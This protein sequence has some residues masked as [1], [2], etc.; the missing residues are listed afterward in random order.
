SDI[1]DKAARLSFSA[2]KKLSVQMKLN[3][4]KLGT[5]DY[6]HTVL[7]GGNTSLKI[8]VLN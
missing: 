1:L 6:C 8:L 4:D 2:K 5:S 7:M 3:A